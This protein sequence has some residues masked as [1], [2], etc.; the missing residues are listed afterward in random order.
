MAENTPNKGQT[1]DLHIIDEDEDLDDVDREEFPGREQGSEM[2]TK[3][4][5]G[6]KSGTPDPQREQAEKQGKQ[7]RHQ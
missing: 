4:K 7:A 1:K 5:S 2:K 6:Q 3:A